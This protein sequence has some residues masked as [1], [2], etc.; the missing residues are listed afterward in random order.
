MLH[1]MSLQQLVLRRA[2]GW[3][4]IE[5]SKSRRTLTSNMRPLWGRIRAPGASNQ[6]WLHSSTTSSY[7]CSLS[8]I[9]ASCSTGS[10]HVT[11]CRKCQIMKQLTAT[12]KQDTVSAD[13]LGSDVPEGR[14]CYAAPSK[15]Q[16]LGFVHRG[17][18]NEAL[19]AAHKYIHTTLSCPICDVR[20]L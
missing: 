19:D 4:R 18:S 10:R 1:F 7:T 16:R 3:H 15:L 5:Q 6:G 17:C 14:A 12:W 13:I 2:G 11:A 20:F 9:S 8:A